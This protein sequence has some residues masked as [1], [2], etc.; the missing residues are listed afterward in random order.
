L[1]ELDETPLVSIVIPVYNSARTILRALQSVSI[2]HFS[3]Y[4]IVIVDDGSTDEIST[5]LQGIDLPIHYFRHDVNKGEAA[6][7]ATGV[8]KSRGAYIAYLDADDEWLPGKLKLQLDAVSMIDAPIKACIA[9]TYVEDGHGRISLNENV[10]PVSWVRE[11]MLG[12]HMDP[13]TTLVVT[14]TAF[15]EIGYYDTDLPRYTD[16][17]WMLRYAQRG[18]PL[19]TIR[20]PLGKIYRLTHPRAQSIEKAA[21]HFLRKHAAFFLEQGFVYGRKAI[22]RRW[23]EVASGFASEHDFFR[24]SFYLLKGLMIYPFQPLHVWA[25]SVNNWFGI[26]IGSIL[27]MNRKNK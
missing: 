4:E 27:Q 1:K 16:W 19:I 26:K 10:Q 17:D 11:L 7:R 21:N 25:W 5:V 23:F 13:G 15:D 18:F 20:Q 24:M 12:C 8:Q 3:N 6:A 2:Q 22:S 9:S 14:R